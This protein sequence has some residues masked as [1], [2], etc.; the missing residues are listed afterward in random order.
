MKRILALLAILVLPFAVACGDDA[1]ANPTPTSAPASAATTAPAPESAPVMP[2]A[3]TD[4]DSKTVNVKDVSR[5]VPLN[6]DITEVVYALGLGS[7][8]VGADISATYPP[9]ASKLPSIGYQRTLSAE[10][11]I[12]LNPT[13]II[14]N[15]GAGPPEVIEQ[16]KQVGIPVVIIKSTTTLEGV[17]VKIRA[18]GKALGVPN[19]AEVLAKQTEKEIQD[20]LTLAGKAKE[21]PKVAFLYL[22]GAS[23]QH[24]MGANSGADSLIVAAKGTDVGASAGIQGSK[25]ITPESLVT[26]SPDVLLVLTAGLQSVGGVEGLLQIPG[27]AQTPAGQNKRVINMDDQYLLGMGPRT[28]QALMELVKFLHP[29]IS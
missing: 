21:N 2:V 6:G 26:A 22:R 13:V 18:V 5:I 3:F 10:G 8:V 7:N 9:E 15:E 14:G 4:K 28:G 23:V 16:I 25:P 19:R 11:I 17:G 1:G 29:G 12:A 24:I 27:V 20:A